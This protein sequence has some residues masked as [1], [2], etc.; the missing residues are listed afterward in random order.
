MAICDIETMV[1]GGSERCGDSSRAGGRPL[2]PT[3]DALTIEYN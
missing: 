3:S 2:P 1:S